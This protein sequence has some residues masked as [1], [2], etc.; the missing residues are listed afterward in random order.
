MYMKFF[1]DYSFHSKNLAD[2]Q[3]T[4][5]QLQDTNAATSLNGLYNMDAAP[6]KYI[7]IHI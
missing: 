6:K 4:A 3:F 7:S 1:Q 5:P 2:I